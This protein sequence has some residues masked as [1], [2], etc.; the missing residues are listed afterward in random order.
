MALQQFI[1]HLRKR[2][3]VKRVS[4]VL[5]IHGLTCNVIPVFSARSTDMLFF[6]AKHIRGFL[7]QQPLLLPS[8]PLT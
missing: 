5:S 3:A 7:P 1:Q 2:D 4:W 8:V 6:P